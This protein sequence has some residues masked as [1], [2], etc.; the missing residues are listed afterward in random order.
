MLRTTSP[1][2]LRRAA[3]AAAAAIVLAACGNAEAQIELPVSSLTTSQLAALP[4]YPKFEPANHPFRFAATANATA[5]DKASNGQKTER[6]NGTAAS[7][8]SGAPNTSPTKLPTWPSGSSLLDFISEGDLGQSWAYMGSTG[9][10]SL[11]VTGRGE[12]LADAAASWSTT[13]TIPA[14]G[15]RELAIVF[16]VPQMTVAGSTED[17]RRARWRARLRAELL[18]NGYPAWSHEALR[19]TMDPN[20]NPGGINEPVVL[21]TFGNSVTW[22]TNDEDNDSTNNS[23]PGNVNGKSSKRTVQL[24][25]GRFAAGAVVD[26]SMMIRA[27]AT[28]AP[29][30]SGGTSNRCL[31]KNVDNRYFCSQ[32]GATVKG[33]DG[34]E[35]PRIYLMP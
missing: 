32:G 23:I 30:T 35:A 12:F 16:I 8:Y 15:S 2:P 26:L 4:G 6:K 14:D 33:T 29:I 1:T 25:L 5:H 24:S 28:T 7:V 13:I 21:Q 9:I 19:L 31:W 20:Q 3:I 34:G 11:F 18:V 27:S 10:P 22:P 17:D